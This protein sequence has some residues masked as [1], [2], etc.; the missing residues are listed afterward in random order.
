MANTIIVLDFGSQ[1]AQL[2]AR[3]LREVQVYCEL[4]P[5]DSV[6]EDILA[7]EPSGFVLSGGPNSIYDPGAPQIPGYVLESKLPILGICYGMQ[8]LTYA[9]GGKVSPSSDKEYGAAELITIKSNPLLKDSTQQVWMSHGDRIET[10]PGGFE[11]LAISENSPVAAM[12]DIKNQRY[13]LQ[14]HPEVHHTP[15]GKEVLRRFAVDICQITPNWTSESV[16]S[17]SVAEIKE[18]VGDQ[19]VLSAVSG[20]VDSSVATALVQKAVGDQLVAIFVDHGLLRKGEAEGVVATLQDN[21]GIELVVVDAKEI[22]F[23]ALMGVTE[24]EKK[25]KII[26]EKFIRIFEEQAKLLG[27]PPFLVQGTIYPDVVE[28]RAPERGHAEKIKTHHNVGGLPE[29]MKFEL[30]EPLR[31]LFKDEVRRVGEAIGLPTEMVWRQ[32]FPGPGLAV[33]CLGEI[34]PER[35]FRLQ[36][37]DA[38]F[39]EALEKAGLLQITEKDGEISGTSQAFAVLLP[40]RS[41]GVMGDVRTYQEAVALRAVTTEDFMTADWARLPHEL[42]A[43]V[44]GRI[45]N[46]VDGINRVVY[47]ITSKPPSTIEWE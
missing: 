5:F 45:V 8:A 43:E 32:P 20:G 14:F 28:S 21:L 35:I 24:P 18:Q 41:V 6:L 2:I 23:K 11:V 19:M 40:V 17:Q 42:L 34:T 44:A 13:G 36:E 15:H 29:D 38:I 3:K 4:F 25:R 7:L 26:G 31:Y 9:L 22:F 16:V 37:A 39:T 33:R 1:Y 46:E 30:I 47:D 12:G 27:M 10:P